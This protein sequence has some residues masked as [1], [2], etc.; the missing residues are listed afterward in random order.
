MTLLIMSRSVQSFTTYAAVTFIAILWH[1]RGGSLVRGATVITTMITAGVLGN[2]AGGHI[3]DRI[4][5]RHP[6]DRFSGNDRFS[7]KMS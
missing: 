2:L 6:I 7:G 1:L 5:R 4:G 3:A